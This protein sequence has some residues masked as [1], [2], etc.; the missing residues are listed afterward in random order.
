MN[1]PTLEA[2]LKEHE[3]KNLIKALSDRE[4]EVF[5]RGIRAVGPNDDFPMPWKI[6]KF[7]GLQACS[8]VSVGG[9]CD[10]TVV[11]MIDVETAE[12]V[13]NEISNS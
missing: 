13:L 11:T 6:Y 3:L 8:I 5:G 4:P 7:P 10:E 2:I 1:S 9:V 12:K